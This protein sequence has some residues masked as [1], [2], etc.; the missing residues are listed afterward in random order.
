VLHPRL[1]RAHFLSN[2]PVADG[3]TI[4]VGD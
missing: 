4:G 3:L 2:R 1:Y